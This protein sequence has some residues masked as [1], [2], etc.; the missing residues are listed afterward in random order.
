[1]KFTPHVSHGKDGFRLSV[2]RESKFRSFVV[3]YIADTL[4][5]L[6]RH[7]FCNFIMDKPSNWA[8]KVEKELYSVPISRETAERLA[9]RDNTWSWLDDDEDDEENLDN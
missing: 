4:C 1:M 2:V 5:S 9:W 3:D 6:T 7:H 8:W